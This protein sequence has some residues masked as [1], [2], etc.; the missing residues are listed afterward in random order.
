VACAIF[1]WDYVATYLNMI[2][3]KTKIMRECFLF[4]MLN[5]KENMYTYLYYSKL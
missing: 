5:E 1:L 4:Q 3:Q 2:A